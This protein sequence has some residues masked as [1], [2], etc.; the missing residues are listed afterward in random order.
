MTIAQELSNYVKDCATKVQQT[1]F[2]ILSLIAEI[3]IKCKDG[4]RIFTAG[5][6]GSSATA[7]HMV[8]DLVKGCRVNDKPGFDAICLSDS[9]T[10]I[11]C[12]ANDFCYDDI[13]KVMLE[14]YATPGDVLIVFSGSGN[15]PNIVNACKYA[16]EAGLCVIGFGGRD[17]GR[18]K[19]FCDVCL[20]AP[21]D[22]MEMLEDMHLI[23]EH[24]LVST[25]R[26]ILGGK[27]T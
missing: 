18:I 13:Y 5:N 25:I 16:K 4:K 26:N 15:S 22:S 17:G 7:S 6:G 12:L 11:T 3:I 27:I 8:N 24:A 19:D 1:D 9:S 20:I 23:Y 10:L 2:A 21:T 14:T